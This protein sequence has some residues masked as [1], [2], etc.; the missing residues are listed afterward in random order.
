M[1]H[2]AKALGIKAQTLDA[3]ARPLALCRFSSSSLELDEE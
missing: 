1:W 2:A 3:L